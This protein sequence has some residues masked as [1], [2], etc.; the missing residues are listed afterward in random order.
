MK[1]DDPGP[2]VEA[3]RR[4]EAA[5]L[6]YQEAA[7][8]LVAHPLASRREVERA[9]GALTRIADLDQALAGHVSGLVGTITEL[10]DRQQAQAEAVLAR[11][12]EIA[13]RK[14]ELDALTGRLARLGGEVG[15]VAELLE[16][17]R[18]RQSAVGELVDRIEGLIDA[19][20]AFSADASGH[21]F[22]DLAADG[23]GLRQ[24][25]LAVKNKAGLLRG[26]LPEA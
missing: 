19:A 12:G 16:A 15:Q 21:G 7:R 2:L 14:Q 17:V 25:L 11:A 20:A 13:A 24:Q 23:S 4:L 26:K 8:H 18:Q 5:L 10:R 1:K 6:E 9:V 22:A 3:A